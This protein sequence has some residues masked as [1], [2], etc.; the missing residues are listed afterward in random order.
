MTPP[1]RRAAHKQ[2]TRAAIRAAALDLISRQ[3]YQATTVAQIAEAADISHTTLF[4]YFESKEQVLIHDDLDDARQEMLTR[5][6][7]GL[8]PFDLARQI[9]TGM[10][11][12]ANA[13]PWSSNA[14]RFRLLR[15]EP[16]LA[17]AYQLEADRVM[18]EGIDFIADYTGTPA[19]GL[20]LRVF[21]AA[22]SAVMMH[23][24]NRADSIDQTTL[25]DL[26]VAIDLLEQGLPL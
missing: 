21:I 23:I 1:G 16:V 26:L 11:T 15:S 24:A 20:P 17:M 5:I 4:R 8:P 13:D 19:D 10:F 12:I 25:E 6:P 9:V 18:Q 7:P 3:G 22:L 2:Q 14:E